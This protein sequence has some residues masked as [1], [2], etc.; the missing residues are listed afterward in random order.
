M[1][2]DRTCTA[3]ETYNVFID[4]YAAFVRRIIHKSMC[5]NA[6]FIP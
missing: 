2:S 4:L 1:Q 5:S 3:Y 6:Q